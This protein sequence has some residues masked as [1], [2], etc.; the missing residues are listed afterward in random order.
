MEREGTVRRLCEWYRR[1]SCF[2]VETAALPG[3]RGKRPP[4]SAEHAPD[5]V[6]RADLGPTRGP[7][8][9]FSVEEWD[10]LGSERLYERLSALIAAW[11]EDGVRLVLPRRGAS[12]EARRRAERIARVAGLSFPPIYA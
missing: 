2:S 10:A 4:A 9:C 11:G 5:L 12:P 7:E 1:S 3:W 6:V 8:I